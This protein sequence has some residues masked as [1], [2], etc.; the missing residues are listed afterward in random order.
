M[1]EKKED[2][3]VGRS[4]GGWT[5]KL[6]FVVDRKG[7]PIKFFLSGGNVNDSD[8]AIPLLQQAEIKGQY[9]NGDKGYASKAICDYIEERGGYPNIPSRCNVKKQRPYDKERY[10][11]RNVVERFFSKIKEFRRI[12]TR[13]DKLAIMYR[14]FVLLASILIWLRCP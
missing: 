9:V 5:T 7:R 8:I 14:G 10:K 11:E 13:Y 12:A 3:A 1:G 6:H 4:R 2:R